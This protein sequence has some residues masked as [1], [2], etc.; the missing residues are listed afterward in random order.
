MRRRIASARPVTPEFHLEVFVHSP[1]PFFFPEP[2]RLEHRQAFPWTLAIL[3]AFL[4]LSCL[5]LSLCALAESNPSP[6]SEIGV[7]GGGSVGSIH[8]FGFASDRQLDQFGVQYAR[9]SWGGLLR[10]RVDYL[11]EA[12]PAVLLREPSV[13]GRDSKALTSERKRGYGADVAPIGVR[14]LWRRNQRWKPYL[15]GDGGILHFKDR[16]LSTAALI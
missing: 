10:A 8:L 14:L 7:V 12:L 11:A 9:H 16:V 4:A 5:I 13:D 3:G 15:I 1:R 2:Q 6:E